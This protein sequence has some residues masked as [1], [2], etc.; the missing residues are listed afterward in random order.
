M[1]MKKKHWLIILAVVC[2]LAGI[3][4][5]VIGVMRSQTADEYS[6]LKYLGRLTFEAYAATQEEDGTYTI[7][8]QTVGDESGALSYARYDVGREEYDSYL[9]NAAVANSDPDSDEIPKSTI[10]RYVYTYRKDGELMD[11][12]YDSYKTTEEV[13][14]MISDANRV[15]PLRFYAFAV[16]LLLCGV[17]ILI[18]AITRKRITQNKEQ[19]NGSIR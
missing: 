6:D 2:L 8:Y 4:F 1:Q 13:S 9:F 18:V 15:D 10:S 17:Y 19:E 3:A 7:Y 12:I 5:G 16:I 14:E 11:A